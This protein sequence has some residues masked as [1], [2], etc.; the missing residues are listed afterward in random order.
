MEA[1]DNNDINN[2]RS[3]R[4]LSVILSVD[5]CPSARVL[6]CGLWSVVAAGG[7]YA[8]SGPEH[9]RAQKHTCITNEMFQFP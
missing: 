4:T 9:E 3:S 5:L 2:T 8:M 7:F 1:N 6:W